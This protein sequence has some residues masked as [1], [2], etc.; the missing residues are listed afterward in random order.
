L[1]CGKCEKEIR[2]SL[3]ELGGGVGRVEVM[4]EKGSVL[5]ETSLPSSRVSAA[6]Q[7]TGRRAVLKGYGSTSIFKG[8]N[9]FNTSRFDR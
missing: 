7:A 4:L 2:K 5:V 8:N 1:K 6:I 9:K 3:S